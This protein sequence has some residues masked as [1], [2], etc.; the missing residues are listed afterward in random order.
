MTQIPTT[1]LPTD[2]PGDN[3]SGTKWNR[4]WVQA[5][6]DA[7]NPLIHSITNPTETPANVLDEVVTARG[8]L[9]SLEDRLNNVIDVDGNFIGAAENN[10]D[11][12]QTYG[13]AITA[14]LAIYMSDGTDGNTAGRWYKIT[15][16]TP[17][18]CIRGMSIDSATGGA[19]A[20]IRRHGLVSGLAG[21]T[22]GSLYYASTAS[23][24]SLTTVL[25]SNGI[26]MGRAA[27]TTTLNL[28]YQLPDASATITGKITT[29]AQILGGL[30][31]LLADFLAMPTGIG[32][33]V[34]SRC[35]TELV[36][37]NNATPSDI[38]G[39]S[40]AVLANKEYKFRFVVHFVTPAGANIKFALT[41]P[42]AVTGVRFGATYT[43]GGAVGDPIN[44]LAIATNIVFT[45]TPTIDRMTVIEGYLR[46]GANAGTVQLQMAQNTLVVGDTKVYVDS[47]VES[48]R[49]T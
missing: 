16:T 19:V 17:Q 30:K 49:L 5:L 1:V 37:N 34:V 33:I 26:I 47:F 11:I 25:T 22:A 41:G 10:T 32:A 13:E 40:F 8:N 46:N 36:K 44:S 29:G 2:D 3:S 45:V 7:I 18:N 43:T 20:L 39:L 4:S 6:L 48:M 42:A 24:G 21:L 12:E 38:T 35:T 9:T 15:A 31:S 28:D 14:G 27:S 23:P